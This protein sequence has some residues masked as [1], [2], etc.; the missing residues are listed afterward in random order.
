MNTSWQITMD[1]PETLNFA[2]F[3][4]FALE[5]LPEKVMEDKDRAW[6]EK[7]YTVNE[8]GS[9]NDLKG[10]WNEWWQLLIKE[11]Q[12]QRIQR[13]ERPHTSGIKSEPLK[14]LSDELWKDFHKWWVMPAGGQM[15]MMS[16]T[17]MGRKEIRKVI[18]EKEEQIG[19]TIHPFSLNID[20]VYAGLE[21]PLEVDLN[22]AVMSVNPPP[23]LNKEWWIRKLYELG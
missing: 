8:Y 3:V 12:E 22:Y 19:R 13:L 18:S 4:G 23:Y 5:L 7:K 6:P 9:L 2:I 21:S 17:T 11:R 14:K 16:F 1:I 15:A 10:A 20:L